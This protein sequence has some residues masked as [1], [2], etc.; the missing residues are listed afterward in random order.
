[1]V[2]T[3]FLFFGCILPRCCL[4]LI[5]MKFKKYQEIQES[6]CYNILRTAPNCLRFMLH[7]CIIFVNQC[8]RLHRLFFSRAFFVCNFKFELMRSME[9][10]YWCLLRL[11]N[12]VIWLAQL[13]HLDLW[14]GSW[15][16]LSFRVNWWETHT[17]FQ[18]IAA[19]NMNQIKVSSTGTNR[20][21]ST[22][23]SR[24]T[25]E[26]SIVFRCWWV[27]FSLVWFFL[28]WWRLQFKMLLYQQQH[29]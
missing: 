22:Y 25:R 28:V 9:S 18:V 27:S 8:R 26:R 14:Y 6:H 23:T 24:H 7:N 20:F 15:H 21:I 10:H 5:K 17:L 12:F 19:S 4:C 11:P 3:S 29:Q 1:M 16:I 2:L 13:F